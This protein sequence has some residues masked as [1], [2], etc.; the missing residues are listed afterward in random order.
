LAIIKD[1]DT[2]DYTIAELARKLDISEKTLAK[3]YGSSREDNDEIIG[4]VYGIFY[5]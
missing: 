5:N 3:Y 2:R 1:I 4:G